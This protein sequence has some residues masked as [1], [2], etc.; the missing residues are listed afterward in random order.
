MKI[1]RKV[2]VI[3]LSL[4][5]VI[6]VFA[7]GCAQ[8]E[9]FKFTNSL[10]ERVLYG[11][12]VY[13]R[14]YIPVEFGTSYKLYVSYYDV[15]QDKQIKDE[16]QD[17]LLFKFNAVTDFDFTLERDD[18]EKIDCSI[19]CVPEVP[20]LSSPEEYATD[21]GDEILLTD[22]LFWCNLRLTN[23]YADVD[24]EF[25][26]KFYNVKI[27]SSSVNGV[28][29][30]VS[31]EGKESFCFDSGAV[32][33]FEVGAKNKSGEVKTVLKVNT[34]NEQNHLNEI[35]GYLMEDGL[36]TFAIPQMIAPRN[37]ESVRIR[38]GKDKFDAVYDAAT[39]YYSVANYTGKIETGEKV[40][41][42]VSSVDGKDFSTQITKPDLIIGQDNIKDFD[43]ITEGIAVLAED[44]DMSDVYWSEERD[45][46]VKSNAQAYKNYYF[47]GQ[48][49]GLGHTVSNFK[50][51]TS[52]FNGAFIWSADGATIKNV[53]FKNATISS[54]NA[55]IVGRAQNSVKFENVAVEVAEMNMRNSGVISGASES[56]IIYTNCLM[57]VKKNVGG[58]ITSSGF[59]GGYYS[60]SVV[61]ENVYTVTVTGLPVSP[62]HSTITTAIL[63]EKIIELTPDEAN[64]LA[65]KMPTLI[66]NKA[67]ESFFGCDK[68]ILQDEKTIKR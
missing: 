63:G 11:K 14:E 2:M 17:T 49:D 42:Y 26:W 3:V 30:E 20:R 38:I 21:V 52:N 50:N 18:G 47:T 29:E 66:L 23:Q 36:V 32:Y 65:G 10:P 9:E 13:F 68:D 53:I 59:M 54:N 31:L 4:L 28:D 48:F 44:I 46:L 27:M 12:S 7:A 55:V 40:R 39:G 5:A 35:T 61:V 6:S 57:Y 43:L 45:S 41:M 24:P 34:S 51:G 16:L 1:K 33:E 19:S 37:G 56:N 22:L 67:V 62:I 15:E 60:R 58:S 64:S 25:E 8:R